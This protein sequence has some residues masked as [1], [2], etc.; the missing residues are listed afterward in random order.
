MRGAARYCCTV[1]M[2]QILRYEVRGIVRDLQVVHREVNRAKGTMSM[3]EFVAMCRAVA[4][5]AG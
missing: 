5:H 4:G 1:S 2:D 3:E